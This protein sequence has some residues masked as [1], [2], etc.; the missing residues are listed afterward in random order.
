METRP[1]RA[2]RRLLNISRQIWIAQ[3]LLTYPF[4]SS[5][6]LCSR[7]LWKGRFHQ[8]RWTAEQLPIESRPFLLVFKMHKGRRMCCYASSP[9]SRNPPTCTCRRLAAFASSLALLLALALFLVLP[10]PPPPPPPPPTCTCRRLA[11][12]ASSLALLLALALFL[13]PPPYIHAP[14][15]HPPHHA[16]QH[17]QEVQIVP[18][19][20]PPPHQ[21]HQNIPHAPK[22]EDFADQPYRGVIHMITGGPALTSTPSGR[23]GTTTAASTMSPS[24]AQ[25]CRRSGPTYR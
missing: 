14:A 21:Q 9:S 23:S 4:L 6:P 13:V 12:F 22:Q 5:L 20:P 15:P 10:P 2:P 11:A 3:W 25:S 19:P 7:L 24:L 17:H 18:P 16:Y 8:R 1:Y